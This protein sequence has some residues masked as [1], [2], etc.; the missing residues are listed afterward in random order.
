MGNQQ[1]RPRPDEWKPPYQ[2]PNQ[3]PPGVVRSVE[4]DDRPTTVAS[5]AQGSPSDRSRRLSSSTIRPSSP[6]NNS[7]GRGSSKTVSEGSARDYQLPQLCRSTL[8]A[9]EQSR[10][11]D[12]AADDPVSA[13]LASSQT[14]RHDNRDDTLMTDEHSVTYISSTASASSPLA[15][16]PALSRAST[17]SSE[18]EMQTPKKAMT[19]EELVRLS[20]G[21]AGLTC[22]TLADLN[23]RSLEE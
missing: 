12:D 8:R 14:R 2:N 3:L 16:T 7:Q 11:R 6:P 10:N 22:L 19:D 4:P 23:P 9:S 1:S 20:R 17:P 21:T 13:W 5:S 15:S 18:L